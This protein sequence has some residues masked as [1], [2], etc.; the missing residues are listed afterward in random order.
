MSVRAKGISFETACAGGEIIPV[1]ATDEVRLIG[2]ERF[3]DVIRLGQSSGE[4][5]QIRTHRAVSEQRLRF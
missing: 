1:D 4:F 5:K 3:V 2:V